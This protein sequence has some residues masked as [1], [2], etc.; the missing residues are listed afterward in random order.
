MQYAAIWQKFVAS[1]TQT[2]ADDLVYFCDGTQITGTTRVTDLPEIFPGVIHL[3]A[4][5]PQQQLVLRFGEFL[6]LLY[7]QPAEEVFWKAA[8]GEH[9]DKSGFCRCASVSFA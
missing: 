1:H 2:A 3:T 4:V 9:L 6:R 7:L 8:D 5:S